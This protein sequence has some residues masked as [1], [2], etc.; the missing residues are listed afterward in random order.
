MFGDIEGYVARVETS[1]QHWFSDELVF[2]NLIQIPAVILTCVVAWLFTRTFERELVGWAERVSAEGHGGPA[3]W[4]GRHRVGIANLARPLLAPTIWL[5]GMW[6]AI[7]FG[8]S[9]GWPVGI[10]R[11]GANLLA[12]WLIIRIAADLVPYPALAKMIAV[13]AWTLTA[14]NILDLLGPTIQLLDSAGVQAGNLRIS[15]LTVIKAALSLAILLWLS[16]LASGLFERRIT[17]FPD[18]TPT[19][20]VLLGKILKLTLVTLAVVISLASVGIDMSAFAVFTGAIGVGIGF[21][22]QKT[23][24]NL[25]SGIILLLDKSIKPGDVIQVGKTYGWVSSLGARYVS[26]ETR[27]GMEYLIPNEDI[28]T[29]QVL[30]WTHQHELVRL[31]VPMRAPLDADPHQVLMLMKEA[32]RR[33][34]RVLTQPPPNAVVMAFGESAIELELRFWIRDAKN[35]VHNIQSEVLL[36]IW[37]L[38][39]EHGIDMPHAKRDIYLK[40]GAQSLKTLLA[41]NEAPLAGQ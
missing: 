17:R 15:L 27:D 32:A 8:R 9:M 5:A 6:L 28:I 20:R 37:N 2:T 25:F 7:V 23:V 38:F 3:D 14:L 26:V 16:M 22:L 18:L 12:A 24:S 29:Q 33:S 10:A 34:S 21:G 41:P 19:A 30:N 40:M 11:I 35:G 39:R 13:A 1:A 31:K 4:I 36:E